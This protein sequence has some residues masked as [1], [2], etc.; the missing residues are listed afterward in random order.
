[1][2]KKCKVCLK[3]V[4]TT[5]PIW[6]NHIKACKHSEDQIHKARLHQISA[7][8][9]KKLSIAQSIREYKEKLA[10]NQ[11]MDDEN[12]KKDQLERMQNQIIVSSTTP[13]F[14]RNTLSS[15]APEY[16]G[17]TKTPHNELVYLSNRE[18]QCMEHQTGLETILFFGDSYELDRFDTLIRN[19]ER[20]NRYVEERKRLIESRDSQNSMKPLNTLY[21]IFHSLYG[22]QS[23]GNDNMFLQQAFNLLKD[24]KQFH[25]GLHWDQNHDTMNGVMEQWQISKSVITHPFL[26]FVTHLLLKSHIRFHFSYMHKQKGHFVTANLTNMFNSLIMEH[27]IKVP[28]HLNGFEFGGIHNQIFI[29]PFEDE[30]LVDELNTTTT[31]IMHILPGNPFLQPPLA[32]RKENQIAHIPRANHVVECKLLTRQQA[33]AHD[34]KEKYITGFAT[35]LLHNEK[36]VYDYIALRGKLFTLIPDDPEIRL[37]WDLIVNDKLEEINGAQRV[38]LD[39]GKEAYDFLALRRWKAHVAFM[40][41]PSTCFRIA[42]NKNAH[43]NSATARKSLKKQI[44]AR[45]HQTRKDALPDIYLKSIRKTTTRIHNNDQVLLDAKKMEQNRSE[46]GRLENQQIDNI[47]NLVEPTPRAEQLTQAQTQEHKRTQAIKRAAEIMDTGGVKHIQK[48]LQILD[49]WDSSIA[50]IGEDQ[51]QK[52]KN[53]HPDYGQVSPELKAPHHKWNSIDMG[54]MTDIVSKY[55][56]HTSGGISKWLSSHV[57]AFLSVQNPN[58]HAQYEIYLISMANNSM[59]LSCRNLTR[60]CSLIAI[61]KKVQGELRPISISNIHIRLLGRYINQRFSALMKRLVGDKQFAV[62]VPG[63][64]EVCNHIIQQKINKMLEELEEIINRPEAEMLDPELQHRIIALSIDIKNAYN[65]LSRKLIFQTLIDEGKD[66]QSQELKSLYNFISFNLA[67]KPML[68]CND[69]RNMS[70]HKPIQSVEGVLQGNP[71]ST[72]M[73]CLTMKK[74]FEGCV[75]RTVGPESKAEGI[76]YA[77]DFNIVGKV[78]DVVPIYKTLIHMFDD[79][80]IRNEY[81]NAGI[82]GRD[83]PPDRNRPPDPVNRHEIKKL[84]P[85][86]IAGSQDSQADLVLP[87]SQPDNV[88]DNDLDYL[89]LGTPPI[90][91]QNVEDRLNEDIKRDREIKELEIKNVDENAQVP[92]IDT[93][94]GIKVVQAKCCILWPYDTELTPI[95]QELIDIATNL[96]INR[97]EDSWNEAL[98]TLS[99]INAKKADHDNHQIRTQEEWVRYNIVQKHEDF[100]ELITDDNMHTGNAMKLLIAHSLA[101]PTYLART[102]SPTITTKSLIEYDEQLVRTAC[103]INKIHPKELTSHVL[104]RLTLPTRLGGIGLTKIAPFAHTN[105]MASVMMAV[106][107][108]VQN[109]IHTNAKLKTELKEGATFIQTKFNNFTLVKVDN[110]NNIINQQHNDLGDNQNRINEAKENG[111]EQAQPNELLEAKQ[112]QQREAAQPLDELARAAY[113]NQQQHNNNNNNVEIQQVNE[114]QQQQEERLMPVGSKHLS[115]L[116]DHLINTEGGFDIEEIRRYIGTKSRIITKSIRNRVHALG[117]VLVKQRIKTLTLNQCDNEHI[118]DQATLDTYKKML[119]AKYVSQMQKGSS[120]DFL[121]YPSV[122]PKLKMSSTS[123]IMRIRTVLGLAAH[124]GLE[125]IQTCPLCEHKENN[126]LITN[127]THALRCLKT[128]TQVTAR[129]NAIL[130]QI[131][132]I[133][134]ST[135]S[136]VMEEF[137]LNPGRNDNRMDVKVTIRMHDGEDKV[138]L[139]DVVIGDPGDHT[140]TYEANETPRLKINQAARMKINHYAEDLK[141]FPNCKFAP[142]AMESSGAMLLFTNDNG[143]KKKRAGFGLLFR[144]LAASTAFKEDD[145]Q[146][147]PRIQNWKKQIALVLQEHN[148]L[149]YEEYIKLLRDKMQDPEFLEGFKQVKEA[150]NDEDMVARVVDYNSTYHFKLNTISH[151]ALSRYLDLDEYKDN[152]Y[153]NPQE[154]AEHVALLE[155]RRQQQILNVQPQP[156]QRIAIAHQNNLQPR[157]IEDNNPQLV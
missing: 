3:W 85:L 93:V 64:T 42:G 21:K 102:L 48:A 25:F 16:D 35:S 73:Y 31:H 87:D 79:G 50:N 109:E 78:T 13:S 135:K 155:H 32:D 7:G 121:S 125:K 56:T 83:V 44:L 18:F 17:P 116:L 124:P 98:G 114:N 30:N 4:K 71:L 22:I 51:L 72:F 129:H 91:N 58:T 1:M 149:V 5:K 142:L 139:G 29:N 148:S 41:L 133:A 115:T 38:T 95:P 9:F 81:K 6:D 66:P 26:F 88:D 147:H 19:H 107:Y 128:R 123:S 156:Q 96:G 143:G 57:E 33:I 113:V 152:V 106:P 108:L 60:A 112:Q 131:S 11:G 104:D 97:I 36:Q 12:D 75:T 54:K 118:V 100:I 144:T 10:L 137:R 2:I 94:T 140:K 74:F 117:S 89:E 84:G 43:Y 8:F 101:R 103:I 76:G 99:G 127:G 119:I 153:R 134:R 82:I 14:I 27:K 49:S 15:C 136:Q 39:E 141:K 120:S 24:R 154:Q 23:V 132:S 53:L 20:A 90:P 122:D 80:R 45:L 65:S 62:S 59:D 52:L 55:K 63:G 111:I 70:F 92:N 28:K 151:N 86:E 146:I 145:K 77:D 105:Y 37:P 69:P 68:Y 126:V 157:L 34:R 138:I 150:W 46:K 130:H 67:E 47:D 40:T 110:D 61:P